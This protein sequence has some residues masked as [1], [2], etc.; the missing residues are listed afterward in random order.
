MK[1]ASIY[2]FIALGAILISYTSAAPVPQDDSLTV[3]GR[4]LMSLLSSSMTNAE[5]EIETSDSDSDQ[6]INV[7][8]LIQA[9]IEGMTAEE[10]Q[11]GSRVDTSEAHAQLIGAIL[12]MIPSLLSG[13]LG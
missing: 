6:E 11:D 8:A 1:S 10:E 4:Q 5:A 13:L 9:F 3:L 2:V 7:D 12:G